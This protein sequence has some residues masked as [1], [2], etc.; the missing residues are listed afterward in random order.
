MK[1]VYH[2]LSSLHSSVS[3]NQFESGVRP[4]VFTLQSSPPQLRSP[5]ESDAAEC[6]LPSVFT[7]LLPC[8]SIS[9]PIR[10]CETSTAPIR[11][12][13]RCETYHHSFHSSDLTLTSSSFCFPVSIS[14]SLVFC[15]LISDFGFYGNNDVENARINRNSQ[16]NAGT[17]GANED[18]VVCQKLCMRE[19]GKQQVCIVGLQEFMVS[20]VE[21]VKE[22]IER[23]NATRS[24]GTT[25]ANEESS[26]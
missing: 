1:W 9:A 2:R 21:T 10:R 12:C 3:L 15:F 13:R 7:L 22:L 8:F 19:D 11:R 5:F 17:T 26:R 25:G 20:H 6:G 23:G 18:S 24:T 4:S 16:R 14:A